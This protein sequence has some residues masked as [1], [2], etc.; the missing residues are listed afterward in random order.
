[1]WIQFRI[2]NNVILYTIGQL[3][4]S[5]VKSEILFEMDYSEKILLVLIYLKWAENVFMVSLG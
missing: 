3:N 5:L 4:R 1:M 2:L